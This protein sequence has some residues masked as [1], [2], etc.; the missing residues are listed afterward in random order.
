MKPAHMLIAVLLS[1]GMLRL[2]FNGAWSG[3]VVVPMVVG[4]LAAWRIGQRLGGLTGDTLGTLNELG[5]GSF[6]FAVLLWSIL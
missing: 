1:S 5:E 3:L 6:L 4:A 2:L